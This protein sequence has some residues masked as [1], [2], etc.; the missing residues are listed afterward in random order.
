M[1]VPEDVEKVIRAHVD[2]AMAEWKE[3]WELVETDEKIA[4]KIIEAPSGWED[5][6]QDFVEYL[7]TFVETGGND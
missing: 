2:S 5:W 3:Y 7:Q 1:K 4:S 6:E